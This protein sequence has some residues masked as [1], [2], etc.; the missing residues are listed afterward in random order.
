MFTSNNISDKIDPLMSQGL[1]KIPPQNNEAEQSVLGCL[2]IDKEAITKVADILRPEDFYKDS[3]LMILESMYELYEKREPIDLLSLANRLEEKKQLEAVGGQAYL[4]TLTNSV[5][6]AA[7][8]ISYAKIVQKKATL[9]RLLKA[10]SEINEL[11]YK[12]T[13]DVD[14]VL[15]KAEQKL[16]KISQKYLNKG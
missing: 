16:F 10:S 3:H 6:T 11:S 13:E 8:V 4:A 5:P 7:H 14:S 12:E 1:N 2:L 9:R 15:D